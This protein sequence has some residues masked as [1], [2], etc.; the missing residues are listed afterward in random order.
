MNTDQL[1]SLLAHEAGPAPSKWAVVW[2]LRWP[3]AA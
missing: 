2:R 1:I 3:W